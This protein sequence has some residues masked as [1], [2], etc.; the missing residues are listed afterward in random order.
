MQIGLTDAILAASGKEK[1]DCQLHS[2]T[3]L[4]GIFSGPVVFFKF[5]DLSS[6]LMFGTVPSFIVNFSTML[7][8]FLISTIRFKL[9]NYL[10]YTINVIF[11]QNIKG[12]NI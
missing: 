3:N 7:M 8:F 10:F 1:D 6:V 11:L 5:T 9:F 2:L 12:A 4:E